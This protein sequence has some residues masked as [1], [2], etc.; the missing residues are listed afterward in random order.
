MTIIDIISNRLPGQHHYHSKRQEQN[1]LDAS[2]QVG[3]QKV[4]P[5][6]MHA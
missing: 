5:K 6:N 4:T 2:G 1:N 3:V